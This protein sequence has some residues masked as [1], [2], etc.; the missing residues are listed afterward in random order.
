M[1]NELQ[2]KTSPSQSDLLEIETWL[3]EEY[4]RTHEGFYCNWTI[5]LDA[6]QNKELVV[7]SFK[8][9]AIGF[10]VWSNNDF[11]VEID[12]FVVSPKC[13]EKGIGRIFYDAVSQFFKE[14]GFLVIKLF[15][16]P[17]E[18]EKFWKKLGLMKFPDR[19][20][21]E[22]DL[23]YYDTLIDTQSASINGDLGNKIELWNVE[24]YQKD[25]NT[26]KWIWYVETKKDELV[27]PIIHP[28]N[29]DWN[30][31]WTIDGE[32]IRESKVKYFDTDENSVN[33]VPFLFI[34]RL[35]E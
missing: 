4:N 27:L 24:P 23:I 19:G 33:F 25:N 18:S 17:R 28:C 3:V 1:I 2:I 10:V 13:R 21:T 7:L 9:K 6:F 30:L 5:I 31:R 15:C 22:S 11:Y 14:E 8:E 12:I 26:P 29:C 34:K 35:V 16:E 20:Y 32:V